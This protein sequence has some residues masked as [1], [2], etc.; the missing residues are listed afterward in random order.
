MER[1][2]TARRGAD[3]MGGARCGKADKARMGQDGFGEVWSG[4]H[5][6]D[7]QGEDGLGGADNKQKG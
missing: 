6:Q 3:G 4:R 1:R 2:G 7:G 5:G